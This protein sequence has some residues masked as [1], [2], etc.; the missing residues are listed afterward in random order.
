[1]GQPVELA[2]PLVQQALKRCLTEAGVDVAGELTTVALDKL[3]PGEPQEIAPQALLPGP[4]RAALTGCVGGA[5]GVPVNKI[6]AGVARR[7]VDLAVGAGISYGDA[8]LSG[9]DKQAALVAAA[10]STVTSASIQ[11]CSRPHT[12]PSVKKNAEPSKRRRTTCQP[13]V[14]AE[15]P[16]RVDYCWVRTKRLRP[17]Y[18]H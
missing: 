5:L 16:S 18:P 14:G 17:H 15:P 7:G 9:Q 2:K 10:Q 11:Q 4:V 13:N 1:M 3:L 6:G 8:R 12:S